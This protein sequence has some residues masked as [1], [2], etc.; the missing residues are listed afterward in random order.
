[1]NSKPNKNEVVAMP[2]DLANLTIAELLKL[3]VDVNEELRSRGVLRTANNPTGDLAEFLFCKTFGW[4]QE[5]NSAKSFDATDAEGRRFQIKARRVHWRNK[6]RQLSAIRDLDGFDFLAAMLFDER[7]RISKSA[8]IPAGVIQEKATFIAHTNSHKFILS[9]A[10]WTFS[11][12]VDV[13]DQ[14]RRT[15]ASI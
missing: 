7:Y 12:V 5:S 3:H 15:E 2:P 4:H 14:L 13:T 11:G 8:L 10:V 9:D 6:S 1:M